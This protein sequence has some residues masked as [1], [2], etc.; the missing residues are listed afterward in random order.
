MLVE[1]V[2]DRAA[3]ELEPV[4]AR[5]D[6]GPEPADVGMRA[7]VRLGAIGEHLR[8]HRVADDAR[9]RRRVERRLLVLRRARDRRREELFLRDVGARHDLLPIVL[10]E[11]GELCER[12]ELA[13]LLHLLERADERQVVAGQ[14]GELQRRL[15]A[16]DGVAELGL[17]R[18]RVPEVLDRALRA[19]VLVEERAHQLLVQHRAEHRPERSR[20]VCRLGGAGVPRGSRRPGSNAT[21]NKVPW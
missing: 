16:R 10:R 21:P 3:A 11:P 19:H 14:H 8:R 6:V 5:R 12:R 13:P 2:P 1:V 9:D 18:E 17:L 7:V 4:P 15:D 20:P